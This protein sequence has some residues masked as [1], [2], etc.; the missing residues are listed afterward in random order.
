MT[1]CI[2]D[3]KKAVQA[4]FLKPFGMTY[5]Y[6]DASK[7]ETFQN[8]IEWKNKKIKEI[9]QELECRMSRQYF[10]NVVMAQ[11]CALDFATLQFPAYSFMIAEDLSDD[12]LAIVDFHK[13]FSRDHSLHQPLTAYVAAKLLGFGDAE[14]SLAIPV[15]PGNLL[16]YCVD[17]ILTKPTAHYVLDSARRYGIPNN[18]LKENQTTRIFWRGLFYRTVVLS[19]LFHDVGY[20]WQYVGRLGK[21]LRKNVNCLHPVDSIIPQLIHNFKDRMM[22]LPLRN[23]QSEHRN[24]SIYENKHLAKLTEKALETHGFPGA[25]AF[26]ALN[27]AIRKSVPC[28]ALDRMHQF[29]VE[30]AAMGIF[31]HDMEGKHKEGL[32]ELSLSFEQDPLSSMISVA[33]YLEEFNRPK[34]KFK[35][36]LKESRMRYYFDCLQVDVDVTPDGVMDV[37]MKYTNTNGKVIASSFKRQE[38]D[39]YFNPSIGY[40]DMNPLGIKRVVYSQK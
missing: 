36:K 19:A 39:D 4:G 14:S 32:H 16:D 6:V 26:I 22:F 2:D 33:D 7:F 37:C 20:P 15:K 17:A 13:K 30:W 23:Y 18:M 29:E 27:D 34:V 1:F 38:T 12:W 40:I 25:I 5:D 21:D 24:D 28:S 35:K 3:F 11:S 31:M 8:G 9:F 10:R